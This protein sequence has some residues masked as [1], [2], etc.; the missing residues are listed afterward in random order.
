MTPYSAL[1]FT[2]QGFDSSGADV[3]VYA[4]WS[5]TG[6]TI[7]RNGLFTAGSDTGYFQITVE[8][9][10]SRLK[11]SALVHISPETGLK[12][13]EPLRPMSFSLDQNFPNPFNPKTTIKYGVKESC[14][15][16]LKVYDIRGRQVGNFI[17]SEHEAGMY[18]YT[19]NASTLASGVYLYKIVMKNY[20]CVKKMVVLK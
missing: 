14:H 11:G 9:T 3:A 7:G 2:A 18:S 5:A 8:D 17:D 19:F 13:S 20:S 15:V 4:K 10:L 12:H 6:G 16:I 1:Q